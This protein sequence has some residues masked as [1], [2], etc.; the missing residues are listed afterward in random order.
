LF[1]LSDGLLTGIAAVADA[2]VFGT[3]DTADLTGTWETVAV[4]LV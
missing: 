4:E 3:V 1:I 2:F